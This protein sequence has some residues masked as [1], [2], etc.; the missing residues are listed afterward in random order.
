MGNEHRRSRT[1]E[2]QLILAL[3]L[4]F[5]ACG[6]LF[7][8]VAQQTTR[9]P[10]LTPFLAFGIAEMIATWGSALVEAHA[11]DD[12]SAA[13]LTAGCFVVFIIAFVVASAILRLRRNEAKAF[14]DAQIGGEST[15]RRYGW[16]LWTMAGILIALGTFLYR[17]LPPIL[18]SLDAVLS[19]G[20]NPEDVLRINETRRDLTKGYVFGEAEYR[21]QGVLRIVLSRGWGY[22]AI[23]SI[24]A[25]LL[26]GSRSRRASL[27]LP[28]QPIAI[29]LMGMIYVGGTGVRAPIVIHIVAVIIGLSMMVRFSMRSLA[30][31]AS[32]IALVIF[33]VAP[34]GGETE[35]RGTAQDRASN[36][37]QRVF[38]GNGSNNILIM[39]A[40][41][42]GAITQGWGRLHVEQLQAALPGVS[43][44]APFSNRLSQMRGG[45]RAETSYAS[46]TYFGVLY[47]DFGAIGTLAGY[48]LIG[49]FVAYAQR[50]LFRRKKDVP[51]LAL[52]G[53]I[54][55][56]LSQLSVSGFSGVA[57][58]ILVIVAFHFVVTHLV[59][60]TNRN[61]RGRHSMTLEREFSRTPLPNRQITEFVP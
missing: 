45:K 58:G 44:N 17:G 37:A 57:V 48:G 30:G 51:N 24:A 31:G 35:S 25:Y 20:D 8:F 32:V 1:T 56:V 18:N 52:V 28:W 39:Q 26:R 59:L 3:I 38:L 13:L 42:N 60:L 12:I 47:A 53:S 34:L 4:I 43:G 10:M 46:P 29:T 16:A 11:T 61:A 41:E 33:V 54:I 55:V 14:R 7:I 27:R 22:L 19:P 2:R 21:G 5:L 15:T 6:V 36:A 50:W 9:A 40:I 23:F 49:V